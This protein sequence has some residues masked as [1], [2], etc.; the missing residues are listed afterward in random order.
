MVR[1]RRNRKRA[2]GTRAPLVTEAVANARWSVDFMQDQFV[3][4]RRFR[5]LNVLD[6]VTKRCL[7]SVV[8]TSISGARVA[9]VELREMAMVAVAVP[10]AT[11]LS[12]IQAD[13]SS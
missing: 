8:D 6:D 9:R 1:R 2:L 4:G 5:I 10:A 3:D 13:P 12:L 7:A 11:A